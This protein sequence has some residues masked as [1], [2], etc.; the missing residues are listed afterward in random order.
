[1]E[2][3]K[4]LRT[5]EDVD[6]TIRALAEYF[7]ADETV[8]IGIQAILLHWPDA[9]ESIRHSPEVDAYPANAQAWESANP[10]FEA[11]EEINA[12]FGM[13]SQFHE[14]HGFYID[15]VDESTAALPK[16]WR[17]RAKV[18]KV[19]AHDRW[20]YGIAPDMNDLLVSKLVAMREKDR[21]FVAAYHKARPLQFDMLRDLLAKM[22]LEPERRARIGSF[23][24]DLHFSAP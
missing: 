21:D 11:S 5:V 22:Q 18:R 8:V 24:R 3:S 7:K 15:G 23:L 2:K 14:A 1:V 4:P 17:A 19:W 13:G 16:D 20:V 12:L 10:G 6:H 9:P